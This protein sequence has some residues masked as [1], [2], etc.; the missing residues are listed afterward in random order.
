MQS[1]R[2]FRPT[3]ARLSW[4]LRTG[5]ASASKSTCRA[6]A[7]RCSLPF[8]AIFVPDAMRDAVGDRAWLGAMLEAEAALARAQAHA[9]VIPADAAAAVA[10]VCE[11][12][13][14]FDVDARATA[15]RADGNPVPALVA[16]ADVE[17]FHHGATSQD[18][19]DT[20]AMLVS[21]SA[22]A[23]I[24]DDLSA[25]AAACARFA[26]QHRDTPM[27]ARTLMQQ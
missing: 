7:R 17:W 26:Q 5:T 21:R 23:L 25:T 11:D 3:G 12:A 24:V 27:I 22:I 20:A 13:D 8:D 15:A 2:R 10:R 1:W 14:R 4:P 19:V 16:V 18:I 9:G 6:S